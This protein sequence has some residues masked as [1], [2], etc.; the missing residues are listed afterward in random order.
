MVLQRMQEKNANQMKCTCKKKK[1]PD[2]P[3]QGETL[4]NVGFDI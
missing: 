2:E 3:L 4:F 1:G